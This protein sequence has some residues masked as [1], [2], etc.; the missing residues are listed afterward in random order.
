MKMTREDWLKERNKG[1]GGS[2]VAAILGK[3]PFATPLT[4]WL[5][6]TGR[7]GIQKE[8]EAMRLGTALEGFVA[9]RYSE[10][11]GMRVQEYDNM[12]HK[13]YLLGNVDRLV[14]PNGKDSAVD[15]NGNIISERILE[16]KTS[17][18]DLVHG[19]DIPVY[20]LTQIMHYLGL[21]PQVGVADIAFQFLHRKGFI[22]KSQERDDKLIDGMFCYLNDWWDKHIIHDIPPQPTCEDDCKALWKSSHKDYVVFADTETLQKINRIKEIGLEITVRQQEA[23]R[24]SVDVMK[25]MGEA[26]TLKDDASKKVVATWKQ[27]NGRNTTSWKSVAMAM[28]A[29]AD[30]I[31]KYT[32]HADPERRFCIK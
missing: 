30:T 22:I 3:S 28:G 13:G 29:D 7:G 19:D 5:R 4:I 9:Q 1:I 14:I 18:R 15:S 2:D 8:T 27:Y 12:L 26:D 32:N 16:C 24:L 31:E 11:T 10:E 23:D 17:S 6:K 25:A 20:Y 21:L